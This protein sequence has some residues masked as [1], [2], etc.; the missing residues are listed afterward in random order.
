M[1]NIRHRHVKPAGLRA[2]PGKARRPAPASMSGRRGHS[3]LSSQPL[4]PATTHHAR[5]LARTLSRCNASQN[6]NGAFTSGTSTSGGNLAARSIRIKNIA[7][8][9]CCLFVC[10]SCAGMLCVGVWRGMRRSLAH[11]S[12]Y[13]AVVS[14]FIAIPNGTLLP[15]APHCSCCERFCG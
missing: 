9:R 15:G 2:V 8:I 12:A 3:S 11:T 6:G 4:S 13:C 10:G 1:R 14:S 5:L 7:R